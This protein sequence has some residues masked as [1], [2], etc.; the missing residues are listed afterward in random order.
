M[1][2]GGAP[3]RP[4]P[5][6]LP[7]HPGNTY[8]PFSQL[9][10]LESLSGSLDNNNHKHKNDNNRPDDSLQSFLSISPPFAPG[11]PLGTGRS[12]GGHVLM[13]AAWAAAQTLEGAPLHPPSAAGGGVGAGGAVEKSDFLLHSIS[14]NFLLPG[15]LNSKFEYRVKKIRNG[16]GIRVRGVEVFQDGKSKGGKEG[17]KEGKELFFIATC[18][19]KL[20]EHS[21]ISVQQQEG[22]DFL[23]D[24]FYGEK[25][26]GSV[27][28][29]KKDPMRDLEEVPGMDLTF[30]R[31]QKMLLLDGDDDEDEEGKGKTKKNHDAFP[32]LQCR[33]V[34]M[35]EYNATRHPMERRQLIF[36]RMIFDRE[37]GEK[38]EKEEEEGMNMNMNMQLCAHLYA[39]DRNSLFIVANLFDL[40]DLFTNMSSLSHTVIFHAEEGEMRFGTPKTS[41]KTTTTT[42]TSTKR[43]KSPFHK[44]NNNDDGGGRWFCMEVFGSRIHGGRAV[45]NCR[46]FNDEG[47]HIA[48]CMQDGLIRF[49][50]DP[51]NPTEEELEMM[52]AVKRGWKRGRRGEKL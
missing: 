1:T 42:T 28:K 34:D 46:I 26:Y 39:S 5:H 44:A 6:P 25:L 50:G 37:K 29:G 33:K 11:G 10:A 45:H 32:G 52:E 9:I 40:G 43:T 4:L 30:Y 12:Y 19:F 35:R 16:K 31:K 8:L 3:T 21:Q 38:E 41:S 49:A 18:S 2:R 17:T 48:T 20:R 23:E 14:G 15:K 22:D 24:D 27:L 51:Q 7:F 36:Y 13:Q 47:T